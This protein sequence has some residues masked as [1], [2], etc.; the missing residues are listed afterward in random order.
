MQNKT[1]RLLLVFVILCYFLITLHSCNKDEDTVTNPIEP[2][3]PTQII[4]TLNR[5]KWHLDTLYGYGFIG[6]YVADT[7][8]I[9]F[10]SNYSFIIN[11]G[12]TFQVISMQEQNYS[13]GGLSGFDKDNVFFGGSMFNSEGKHIPFLKKWNGSNIQTYYLNDTDNFVRGQLVIG[14]NDI[15]F[16]MYRNKVYHFTNGNFVSYIIDTALYATDLYQDYSGNIYLFANKLYHNPNYSE[17]RYVFN[18]NNFVLAGIDS[19]TLG[20]YIPELNKAGSDLVRCG[21][22]NVIRYFSNNSWNYLCAAYQFY[23]GAMGG[24]SKEHLYVHASDGPA[25]LGP[26]LFLRENNKWYVENNFD[27]AGFGGTWLEYSGNIAIKDSI[28]YTF[29]ANG[30]QWLTRISWLYK[31]YPKKQIY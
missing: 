25:A 28:L 3:P 8:N 17:Y 12:H 29:Q 19:L 1:K 18:G 20:N 27:K 4:D 2:P 11:N 7:S 24:N 31:G 9:F 23:P 14:P 10:I 22:D 15:W 5:Y 26:K 30:T 6:M 13:L 21:E 16:T